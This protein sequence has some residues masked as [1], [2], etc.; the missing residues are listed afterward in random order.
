M[1]GAKLLRTNEEDYTEMTVFT[2]GHS[3]HDLEH[4]LRL[5]SMH[6]VEFLIDVR[7]RPRSRHV[8]HF[9][10]ENL[11]QTLERRGIGYAWLGG[12]LGGMPDDA[13]MYDAEG[14]VLYHKLA[15]TEGFARGLEK[16]RGAA[17]ERRVAVMCGEENPRGCHRMLL[18]GRV[19]AREGVRVAHIRGDGRLEMQAADTAEAPGKQAALFH[20]EEEEWRSTRSVL[21]GNRRRS[22]SQR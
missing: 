11:R 9:N 8:P 10:R 19:L 15:R 17:G 2:V 14:H 7:S 21:P 1:K 20:E 16:L 22:S 3:N 12:L 5:L 4:F 6:G 18:I 13:S